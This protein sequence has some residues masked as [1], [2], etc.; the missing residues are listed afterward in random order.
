MGQVINL[1]SNVALT[2]GTYVGV[3]L[4]TLGFRVPPSFTITTTAAGTSV[5]IAITASV[6]VGATTISVSAL[7]G[8]IPAQSKIYLSDGTFVRTTAAAISSATS[9]TVAA[10][11][12]AIASGITGT[13]SAGALTAGT[14]FL[15]VS[16]IST[17]LDAGSQLTF[18]TTTVTLSDYAP[19]GATVL[20]TLPTTAAI[21][22]ST[23]ATTNALYTVAS[24][25]Q[26]NPSPDR[27]IVETTSFNSGVGMEKLATATGMKIDLSFQI[28]RANAGAE[29]QDRG[30][31]ILQQLIY[32][33]AYIN[34]EI[35]FRLVRPDAIYQGAAIVTD[36]PQQGDLQ[37][38]V[39]QTCNLQG[40]GS[41]FTRIAL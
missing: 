3:R 36:A 33:P 28:I 39:I 7:S 22:A 41:A 30:G 16:A 40:Q 21:T 14:Q 20:E 5:N 13:W 19:A 37:D 23:T 6:A 34:R 18:G 35:Y 17:E 10:V 4:L 29:V 8:A 12:S 26:A 1:A 9:L 25:T 11:Q 31:A 2:T 24:V 38:R 32:D 27:K 15:P